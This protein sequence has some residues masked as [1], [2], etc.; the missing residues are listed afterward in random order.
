MFQRYITALSKNVKAFQP[1]RFL[2]LQGSVDRAIYHVY[3]VTVQA[4]F[5][6]AG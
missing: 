4:Y 6:K 2:G 3:G 1:R 5:F